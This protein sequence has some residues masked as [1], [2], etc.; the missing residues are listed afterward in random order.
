M[1]NGVFDLQFRL[2]ELSRL[3]DGL[4]QLASAID[5]EGF[6]RYTDSIRPTER[7]SNA[8]RSIR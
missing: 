7:K 3:G 8:G 1:L 5:W 2:D 6:R 4:P